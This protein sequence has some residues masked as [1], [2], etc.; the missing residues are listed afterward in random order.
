MRWWQRAQRRL[1]AGGGCRSRAQYGQKA[2]GTG[3]G[4]AFVLVRRVAG[5]RLGAARPATERPGLS[6]LEPRRE[7]PIGAAARDSTAATNGSTGAV[8]LGSGGVARP[9]SSA[10][11]AS[12]RPGSS[13]SWVGL[14]RGRSQPAVPW[15]LPDR[16]ITPTSSTWSPSVSRLRRSA[17]PSTT[18]GGRGPRGHGRG[19]GA[20]DVG[21]SPASAASCSSITSGEVSSAST[22]SAGAAAFSP[23][24]P[25]SRAAVRVWASASSSSSIFDL[26]CRRPRTFGI[27]LSPRAWA[28]GSPGHES[29]DASEPRTA[30]FVDAQSTA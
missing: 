4:R 27:P 30:R 1:D 7:G 16:A 28:G 29:P 18:M 25:A 24:R 19:P 14:T 3:V 11:V 20:A 12:C 23:N 5:V 26:R 22:S 9:S 6:W 17:S 2:D 15:T 21:I 8:P 10:L 13:V